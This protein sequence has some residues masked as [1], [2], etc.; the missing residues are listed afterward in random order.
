MASAVLAMTLSL[1]FIV[2]TLIKG[3]SRGPILYAVDAESFGLPRWVDVGDRRVTRVGRFIR[4]T[5]IDELPELFN[6]L[7]GE[8]RMI[9]PRPERPYFVERLAAELPRYSAR[10]CVKPGITGL[11]QVNV[12]Y[13]ASIE[14]AHEKLWYDLYYI[15]HRGLLLD[16]L[17]VWRTLRV[18]LLQ[19]GA[20]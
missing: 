15:K 2:A 16:L 12:S 1:M 13:G 11:A 17:S 3:D 10:N 5:W 18:V 19:E 6:V 14:D 9:G 8:M 20:R 7:R 4:C